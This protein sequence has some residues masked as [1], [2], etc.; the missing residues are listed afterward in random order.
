MRAAERSA[1]SPHQEMS[2]R[3][4]A[5]MKK[6]KIKVEDDFKFE[7][8]ATYENMKG[9]FE[10]ISIQR[11][12]MVIRWDNGK[13]AVTTTTVQKRIMERKAYEKKV[14]LQEKLAKQDKTKKPKKKKIVEDPEE[15]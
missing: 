1:A 7:V 8:G 6:Q 2:R 4:N 5:M 13:E 11:E 10:V 14:Q 3:D 12:A 9:V 15:D